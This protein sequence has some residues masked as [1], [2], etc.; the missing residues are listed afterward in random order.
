[1]EERHDGNPKM[2]YV[3]SPVYVDALVLR[4]RDA[5]GAGGTLEERLYALQD[6]NWNVTA[7]VNT[8]GAVQERYTYDPYG[9]P[10]ARDPGTWDARS[11]SFGWNYLH[12]GGRYEAAVGLYHFRM[13]EYSAT[14]GRWVQVDPIGFA[15]GDANYYV[16][17]LNGPTTNT[18]PSGLVPSDPLNAELDRIFQRG[19]PTSQGSVGYR[20]GSSDPTV[21]QTLA[22][23]L[24]QA[25]IQFIFHSGKYVLN[26]AALITPGPD[27]LIL[28]VIFSKTLIKL[29]YQKIKGKLF[30]GGKE[31]TEKEVRILE[32]EFLKDIRAHVQPT[33]D[34]IKAGKKHPHPND[35][36]PFNNA[37]YGY[38]LPKQKDPNYYTEWVHAGLKDK[39]GKERI[40]T[41]KCGEVYYSHNHYQ[42]GSFIPIE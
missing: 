17:V 24:H 19:T 40:I 18:D 20:Q 41:G 11:I 16:Y 6:A 5:D 31:I 42:Q 9:L 2:Q 13:R 27:D 30:K 25:G 36:T 12:Q 26:L 37:G 33:L 14:L 4:D 29:G 34:R 21:G 8:S 39:P 15:A 1:L 32:R 10:T 28:S 23:G 3:W 35:G 38:P 22:N 7:L